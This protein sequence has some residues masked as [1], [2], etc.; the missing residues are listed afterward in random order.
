[1]RRILVICK[2]TVI[3]MA[4]PLAIA[5]EGSGAEPIARFLART[6]QNFFS[7]ST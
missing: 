5:P 4:R 3:L 6:A 2:T 7:I 1:V